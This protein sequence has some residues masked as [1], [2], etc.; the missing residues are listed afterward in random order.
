M[1]LKG[2]QSSWDLVVAALQSPST[3]PGVI[4]RLL[5]TMT[6]SLSLD[7]EIL[8]ALHGLNLTIRHNAK[9]IKSFST[10]AECSKLF[11]RLLLLSESSTDDI[12]HQAATVSAALDKVLLSG[13]GPQNVN[14][15]M[16]DLISRE[17]TDAGPNSLS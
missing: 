9:A 16:M 11:S 6:E 17:L 4:E 7:R 15:T 1:A 12:A 13:D 8:H 2:E 14:Q 3:S 5:A 10:S